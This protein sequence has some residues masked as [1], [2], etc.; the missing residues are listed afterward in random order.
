MIVVIELHKGKFGRQKTAPS[1]E[2]APSNHKPIF[3]GP[4]MLKSST[5]SLFSL[6][7]SL[8]AKNKTF[9]TN[10]PDTAPVRQTI[11]IL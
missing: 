6:S 2:K 5:S 4:T 3:S 9:V 10:T 7:K 8:F 11:F 1:F